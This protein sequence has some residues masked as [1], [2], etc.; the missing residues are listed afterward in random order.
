[1]GNATLRPTMNL[2]KL[3]L[4]VFI[5]AHMVAGAPHK[6][7]AARSRTSLAK[8]IDVILEDPAISRAHWGI[9]VTTLEGKPL[10]AFN[11]G[12]SFEPASNAKLFTTAAAFAVFSPATRFT[13][14]VISRGS[15]DPQGTLDGD[16]ILEGAGDPSISGRSWPYAGKT[17]RPDPPLQALDALADQVVKSGMV[18]RVTGRVVG[19]DRWFPFERYGAGWGWD[20]LQWEYGAPVSA[21]SVNDNVVYL[22]L[23]PG[24]KPGDPIAATWNPPVPY[25]ALENGALTGPAAP[26]PELGLDRQPGSK[27]VRLYG[28]LPVNSKGVHLALAIEDPAEFAALAFRQILIDH[29]IAV[30]GA[31]AAEHSFPFSTTEF[32]KEVKMP[33]PSNLASGRPLA[34]PVEASAER[35]LATYASPPLSQDL[36]VVNKVSQNLHAELILHD[37]GRSVLNDGSTAAGARV[38]RQFLMQAGVD[39]SDFLFFDG[40]GLSP[41]DL[42]TPRAATTL[43]VYAARQPW[44]G[45]FRATLPIA[46]VDGTLAARFQQS[47]VKAKL[48]AKTGTLAEVNTLSGY[49]TTRSGKTVVLSI[50]CND[51]DPAGDGARKATD[52]IIEAI[53]AAL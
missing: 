13:T 43:L 46:G 40:S 3:F 51:H 33:L 12:Q 29:G 32:L 24:E 49:L 8:A 30:V 15:I 37:L 23:M 1:M 14:K 6:S 9:S 31:S 16:I 20:D 7:A 17:E 27:I 34:A 35:V 21:L 5:S 47:P 26:K 22:D 45:E 19:D 50:L 41:Q 53:Y 18:R 28:V 2:R 10:Y 39:P 11:D 42:I 4:F 36:M 38:V 25:Y 48:L 52:R 44:G